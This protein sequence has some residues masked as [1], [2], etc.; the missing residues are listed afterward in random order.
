MVIRGLLLTEH[1][2]IVLSVIFICFRQVSPRVFTTLEK[3]ENVK[4]DEKLT[5]RV[6]PPNFLTDAIIAIFVV[7]TAVQTINPIKKL[8]IE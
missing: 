8:K 6:R 7:L 3:G 5:E 4:H 2:T 1:F